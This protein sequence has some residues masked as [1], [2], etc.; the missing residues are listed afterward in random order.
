M[1]I[2]KTTGPTDDAAN[3][4][5][6]RRMRTLKKATIIL[7]GG[8]SVYDCVIR[9]LSDTGAMLQ[10]APLGIPNHFDL[11]LDAPVPSH[12]C[13]VR[14]RTDSAMGVSFDDVSQPAN[15]AA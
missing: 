9:N 14:W 1:E 15:R 8:Y 3:R 6:A 7:H 4:R 5:V 11:R 12:P 10:V 13:T 2:E